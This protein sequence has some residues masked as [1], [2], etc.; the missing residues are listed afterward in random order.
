[1]LADDA[2]DRHRPGAFSNRTSDKMTSGRCARA[3]SMA[4]HS[5]M[6]VATEVAPAFSTTAVRYSTITHSSSITDTGMDE[7]G[8]TEQPER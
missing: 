5:V 6:A 8:Q 1:M 2:D 7:W 4:S 3:R